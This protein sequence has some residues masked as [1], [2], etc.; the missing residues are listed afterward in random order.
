S[1]GSAAAP[2]VTL[3]SAG[4]APRSPLR[5]TL[6]SGSKSAAT[7]QFSESVDQSLA[8]TPTS[9]VKIPPI[10]F[11]LHTNVGSVAADGSAPINYSYSDVSVVDDGSISAAQRTQLESALAPIASLTGS[12]TL[13]A[14]NQ[15]VDSHISGT[16]QLDPS[17]AQ[18][19]DQFSD[20]IGAV[21]VPFPR[22][23]V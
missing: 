21:A 14:R 1:S 9:S 12:G 3:T 4:A 10:R 6:A 13:T 17:V 7:L 20:Q 11:V 23:A 18:I 22:E 16:E 5:L 8:G 19:T 2:R 15:I